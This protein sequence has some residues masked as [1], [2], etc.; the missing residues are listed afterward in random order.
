MKQVSCK[1]IE[2]ESARIGN[3]L[4]KE[5]TEAKKSLKRKLRRQKL[6]YSS[7]PRHGWSVKW[8]DFRNGIEERG[9]DFISPSRKFL[10]SGVTEDREEI[11]E[12]GVITEGT[13]IA[14]ENSCLD[15]G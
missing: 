11:R 5:A 3:L 9:S 7:G 4:G 8:M 6:C 2:C 14:T 12:A 1:H 15:W 10:C 13:T